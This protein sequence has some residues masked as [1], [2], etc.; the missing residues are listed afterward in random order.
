MKHSVCLR[1]CQDMA[2]RERIE[3]E[4]ELDSEVEGFQEYS[5]ITSVISI[6]YNLIADE[7]ANL[8][9]FQEGL[10]LDIGCGLGDLA[11]EVA[12]RYPKLHIMGADISGEA[13]K[14]ANNKAKNNSIDNVRFEFADVHNLPYRDFCFNLILSHGS[15]HH[16]KEPLRAFKEIFRTLKRGGLAYLTDLR[17]D[18]PI[19]IVK[20][21]EKNLPAAQ[22]KAF[23]HSVNASWTPTELKQILTQAGI[24]D[25]SI[26]EQ[27]FSRQTIFKNR[28][29]L[30][31]ATMR[32]ADYTKLSQATLIRKQ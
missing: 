24:T 31:K 28:E 4:F 25:F 30:R 17:K 32:N 3:E 12:R 9:N 27:K 16:W 18:A 14:K 5:Y 8:G 19:E 22:A 26:T 2:K 15:I 20:E 21:V 7:L 11:I 6:T 29:L 13:I 23:M 10:A 1:K